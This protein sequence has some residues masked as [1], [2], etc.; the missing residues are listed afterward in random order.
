MTRAPR[1]GA[2]LIHEM[3]DNS[4]TRTNEYRHCMMPTH[5][6][7]TALAVPECGVAEVWLYG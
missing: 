5:V 7:A 3:C 6:M 4:S 1:Q 2:A